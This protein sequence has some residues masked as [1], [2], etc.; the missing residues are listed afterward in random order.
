[1]YVSINSCCLENVNN[2]RKQFKVE[3]ETQ[4]KEVRLKHYFQLLIKSC[5]NRLFYS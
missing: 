5:I 1:M 4:R 3:R 2:F